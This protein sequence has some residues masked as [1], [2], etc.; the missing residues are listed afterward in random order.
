MFRR[1]DGLGLPLLE[2]WHKMGVHVQST[3]TLNLL[4]IVEY[5]YMY[6]RTETFYVINGSL[7][8]DFFPTR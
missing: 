1:T 7:F 3:K 2:W 4:S 6:Y 5:Y 8:Y